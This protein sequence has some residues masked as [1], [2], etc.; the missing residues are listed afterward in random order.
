MD[1]KSSRRSFIKSVGAGIGAAGVGVTALAVE[2]AP[3]SLAT[4]LGFS[5]LLPPNNGISG[6]QNF[7]SSIFILGD[8]MTE[9]VGASKYVN[10]YAFISARSLINSVD[11]GY[12]NDPGCGWHVDV[13]QSRAAHDGYMTD[14]VYAKEGVV[15][16]RIY[17][18][19]QQKI[20]VTS[21][22][23]SRACVVYDASRSTSGASILICKNGKEIYRHSIGLGKLGVTGYAVEKFIE[24]DA[25]TVSVVGGSVEVCGI[26]TLKDSSAGALIYVAGKSGAG[27]QDFSS[28]EALDEIAF[29]MNH[30]RSK[31]EKVLVLNL[32]TNNI[33][34]PGR[35]K[36]PSEMMSM[37]GRFV[38][39]I[40][41]RCRPVKY[42][43]SIPP[44]ADESKFLA[45]DGRHSHADYVLALTDFCRA[46]G[47]LALRYD[48]TPLSEVSAYYIDGLHPN[49]DGHRIKAKVLCDAFGVRINPY[50]RTEAP[51]N[52][53]AP[54]EMADSWRPFLNRSSLSGAAHLSG[55]I[56][57]LS[58]AIEPNGSLS[59][60][61]GVLPE[62]YRPVGRT[63]YLVG[64]TESGYLSLSIKPSG[65][66]ALSTIPDSFFS[67]EG[68]SFALSRS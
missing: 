4:P 5:D 34:N 61:I 29:W 41:S 13:N 14:G 48:L 7:S 53:E 64:A 58:G 27:Y 68:I 8:S 50:A 35:V 17:L 54:I 16:S 66:I 31:D 49:D 60:V 36:T 67:L 10:G 40:D 32:G 21:R 51:K 26:L 38:K 19:G 12:L 57:T 24:T 2:E 45:G 47:H 43:F 55:N 59:K 44:K 25:L 1:N 62:N 22:S 30:E 28:A 52:D 15:G 18:S 39:E 42:A 33:Y 9:S 63:C 56:V 65:E 23:F 3:K 37:I 6:I 46:H 20:K 11:N